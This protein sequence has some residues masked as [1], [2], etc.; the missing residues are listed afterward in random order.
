MV[1][2]KQKAVHQVRLYPAT[3]KRLKVR[4]A[5]LGIRLAELVDKLS[6]QI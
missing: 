5:K 2:I 4:A 6:K 3:Y 1:K